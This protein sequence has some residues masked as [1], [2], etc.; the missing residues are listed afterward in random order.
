MHLN[1]GELRKL[2]E[3][4]LKQLQAKGIKP[5]TAVIYI[6]LL[7]SV[8]CCA[9]LAAWRAVTLCIGVQPFALIHSMSLPDGHPDCNPRACRQRGLVA[10]CQCDLFNLLSSS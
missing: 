6:Q 7:G 10:C 8:R 4:V 3:A 1:D 5:D 9:S 2:A